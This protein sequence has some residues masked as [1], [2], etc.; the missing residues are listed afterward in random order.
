MDWRTVTFDWNRARAFLVTAE[1]GSF[2][3]AARAL[4][5]TQPTIGRQVAAL[6]EELGLT[7]FARAGTQLELSESGIELLEHV[8]AMGQA[9]TKVSIAATGQSESIEGPVAITASEAV[10]AYL[11]PP[12]VERLRLEH[13]G[14][15]LELV[16][17]NESRDLTRRE[18]DI[19]IRNVRPSQPELFARKVRDASAHMYATPEYL[20]RKGPIDSIDDLSKLEFF[21]FDTNPRVMIDGMAR[22]GLNVT[23]EQFPVA[24]SNHLVQW[25]LCKRGIGVAYMMA[26]VGDPEPSVVRVLDGQAPPFPTPLWL[27]CHE[28]LRTSRRI[29]LVFDRLVEALATPVG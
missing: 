15:T 21:G 16:A 1:E 19:A 20:A 11:L 26:E 17:S 28:E 14:I 12:V 23:A 24:T 6:E 13:P 22:I 29:R 9:A 25:E 5:S 10:T 4:G 7:L 3:A 18:A 8:R 2:S 27:A